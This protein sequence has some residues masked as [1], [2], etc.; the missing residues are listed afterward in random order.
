MS[1]K[2]TSRLSLQAWLRSLF[3]QHFI[4]PAELASPKTQNTKG[5]KLEVLSCGACMS[6][7]VGLSPAA[8]RGPDP[9]LLVGTGGVI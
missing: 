7:K 6:F 1:G 8:H 4:C 9:R 3:P 5:D 2:V